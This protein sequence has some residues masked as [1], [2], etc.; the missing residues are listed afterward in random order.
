MK[1]DYLNWDAQ[2]IQQL[3]QRKLL[4]TSLYT[5]QYYPGSDT[6]ILIDLFAWTFDALTYIMN[7]NAANAIFEDVQLYEN[8]NRIVKLLSY[9]PRGYLTATAQFNLQINNDIQYNINTVLPDSVTIP[10]FTSITTPK[11]D[12]RGR[13]VKYSF[14]EDYT[15][16]TYTSSTTY[17]TTLITPLKWPVLYN[18]QFKC[19]Q[20]IF[21][22]IGIPYESF[23]LP[24]LEPTGTYPTYVDHNHFH[25]Y[26]KKI[27]EQSGQAEYTEWKIVDNLVTQAG[28]NDKFCEMRLDENKTYQL[29]FG[30]NIHGKTL[31]N[32]SSIYII[33]LQSNGEH[34]VIDSGQIIN[35]TLSLQVPNFQSDME[36]IDTCFGGLE[37]FK[38]NYSGVFISNN[39][40]VSNCE[41]I[42]LI[43]N[44]PSSRPVPHESV[45][46][47]K[48]NAPNMFRTGNR[49]VTIADYAAY[50]K[51]H[52][53]NFVSDIWVCNN[54][55]YRS[56]FYEWL[57]K[58]NALNISIRKYM[59]KYAD[60]C[61][62]NN[63]YLWIKTINGQ[64]LLN[65]TK[66]L[67]IND[68]RRIKSATTELVPCEAI[69]MYFM[70]FVQHPNYYFGIEQVI[71][72]NG[73]WKPPIKISI[74]KTPNS[75]VNNE[76]IKTEV[77]EIITKYFAIENQMLGSLVNLSDIEKEIMQLGYIQNIRTVYIP[78]NNTGNKFWVQGLSFLTFT[79]T[80][81]NFQD[82]SIIQNNKALLP[83][84]YA[85]LYTDSIKQYIQIENEN[86]FKVLTTG[87]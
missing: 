47:I 10:K 7:N 8:L 34:G 64:D 1:H 78:P 58:Y 20:N 15:F 25:I 2:S 28:N 55:T 65:S 48:N 12:D 85:V 30:D 24:L 43:N 13:T 81:I 23:S 50:I 40:F 14:V 87:I 16:N 38:T 18:G 67:I 68:C 56:I 42:I 62:F 84:Q 86:I 29:K 77:S 76:Q 19:Y 80:L 22:A 44:G 35:S 9:N 17:A 21:S 11:K 49:L 82:Y 73:T 33:Y 54:E 46:S 39:L 71:N 61:D 41:K 59:Y 57:L 51:N 75:F 4:N 6:K 37:K 66:D 31:D 26:V 79:Q 53:T 72:S 45:F 69:K 63:I 3:L 36:L 52:Y 27:N 70:P 32:G 74:T 83:F 60:A 5:D